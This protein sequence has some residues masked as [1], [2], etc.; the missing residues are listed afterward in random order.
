[1]WF[2]PSSSGGSGGGSVYV[3]R[4]NVAAADFLVGDF[5]QDEAYH[6]LDISSIVG[7]GERLVLIEGYFRHTTIGKYFDFAELTSGS[8]YNKH[9]VYS[10]VTNVNE[11][12]CF[13]VK[14]TAS[15]KIAYNAST[16]AW[17]VATIYIRGWFEL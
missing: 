16:P 12:P 8:G 4:G 3:D 14:T 11:H 15:G 10:T 9:R 17:S 7:V 13:W 1:M 2:K 6:E 5:T